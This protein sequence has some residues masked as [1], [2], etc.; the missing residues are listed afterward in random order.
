[1]T[2][3]KNDDAFGK[4][5]VIGMAGRYPGAPDIEQFWRNLTAGKE[6]ITF[7]SD[8]ELIEDGIDPILV[9][10]PNYVKAAGVY[11]GTYLFDADFFGY[12]P[13]EAE[14][15]DPQHRI[16]LECSYQALEHAGYDPWTYDGRIG[17][18]AGAGFTQYLF[19]LLALPDL[20]R[21][22]SRFAL[23]TY[24]DKD[25]LATRVG[26]KLGLRGLCVTVQTACS[27][28]LV[29][30]GLASQCLLNYQSDMVLA[31]GVS[32]ST[33]ERYG[34]LYQE[35]GISSPDGHCRA[36]D[37][38]SG[39]IVSGSGAGVVVLKRFSDALKDR[40]TI[41]AVILGFGMN[42]DGA[43]RVGF[44]APGVD[45]Q[46]AVVADAIAMAGIDPETIG[47]VECH[48]TGTPLGDPIE[49]AALTR[50]FREHTGKRQFCAIGSVK[51]NIGHTDTA[52]GVA[53]F[54]KAVLALEH[55]CIPASLHFQTPNPEIDFENSPFFVNTG[56]RPWKS[57]DGPRRA[58]VSSLG[59]GGTNAHVILEEPPT[60]ERAA[61]SKEFHLLVWSART[62]TALHRLTQN[63]LAHLKEHPEQQ[64]GDVAYTLQVGRQVFS[65]RRMLVSRNRENAIHNLE[66]LHLFTR[67][68]TQ[69]KHKPRVTFLFPGQGSQYVNM[70]KE[71]YLQEA[72][73]RQWIDR[74]AEILEPELGLD[75]RSLMFPDPGQDQ[76]ATA[77][78][79]QVQFTTPAIFT[80]EYALAKLWMAWGV[81]PDAL[82]GHSI[83]EYVAACLSG[84]FSLEDAL[85]LV[86]VRG[87]LMQ[88]LPVGAMVAVMLSGPEMSQLLSTFPELSIAAVNGPYACVV[89]GAS[90]AAV[91]L[92]QQL[93]K[94]GIPY[95]RLHIS[96]A[97]HS[98]MMEPILEEFKKEVGKVNLNEP[99]IPYISS[100]SGTWI[101]PSEAT[102]PAYWSN[103]IRQTVQFFQGVQELL[104]VSGQ[105]LLETGPGRMLSDLLMQ[106]PARTERHVILS[107][108]PHPKDDP[109]KAFEFLLTTAG[110]LWLEGVQI[111]WQNFHRGDTPYRVPLPAYPFE[112]QHY[113]LTGD[114]GSAR[115]AIATGNNGQRSNQLDQTNEVLSATSSRRSARHSNSKLTHEYV[116]PRDALESAL[117]HVWRE[118]FGM[119]DLGV[120][121]EFSALGGHSLLAMLLV[122]RMRDLF[123]I[124]FSLVDLQRVPTIADLADAIVA[125]LI[126]G[127]DQNQLAG[128]LDEV[129]S[130]DESQAGISV[131]DHEPLVFRQH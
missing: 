42:N 51:T 23:P 72:S 4:I 84:V 25:F 8:D 104:R 97:G 81:H 69:Q 24:N 101:R 79:N 44:T 43:S 116:A 107:S 106:Y 123:Q 99:Q 21:T 54:T 50:S 92:E 36:F 70:G 114:H 12:T 121:D 90:E 39:G 47:Y 80:I 102:D 61:A 33:K 11:E 126:E 20:W 87:R 76:Q 32:L 30:I 56:L 122:Q 55:G 38:K 46:A 100:I 18:F 74:C 58:G 59:A 49:I 124:E 110:Q 91:A 63:L 67:I 77:K 129:E 60:Q 93:S 86:S 125:T 98:R 64:I 108:L 41:H 120:N 105:I 88:G 6:S 57:V 94:R 66:A 131:M 75:I 53:G 85:H 52:A 2:G 28:S 26:Y 68:D 130:K 109:Q 34:Y 27:T 128:M 78:L 127:V 73:F 14:L 89:S 10:D 45:G 7:F 65:H 5:A 111:D 119:E 115:S 96:H 83:G 3:S 103:H 113:Q 35:G 16:F 31:G 82:L 29:A 37:A 112:G 62:A 22:T 17:V 40:D 13:R 118:V 95:R 48:G 19:E 9:R 15:L 117:T 71:L 1:M